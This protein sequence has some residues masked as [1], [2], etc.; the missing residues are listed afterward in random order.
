MINPAITKE[1]TGVIYISTGKK[2]IK[3]AIRS[4]LSV[5]KHSPKI[6]I[7]LFA[8]WQ[9][10]GFDFAYSCAPF[11]T[12]ENIHD[13]QYHSKVYYMH[14]TP[15]D[16]TL[17]LDADTKVITDVELMFTLLDRFDMALAHAPE[18]VSRLHN[19]KV[20]IPDSF[21]QYNSGVIVYKKSKEIEKVWQEWDEAFAESKSR[22][23]QL[24]FREVLWLSNI[25]IATLAPEYI[26]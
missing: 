3:M 12:V 16:R 2:H 24:T 1:T 18:R 11:T 22:D 8:D 14:K 7:H 4:A 25:R 26:L 6:N 23:D 5:R 19:W 9:E 21:P 13:V 17:Y 10:Q 15:Y 20:E